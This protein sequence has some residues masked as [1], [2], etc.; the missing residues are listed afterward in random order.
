MSPITGR[1]TGRVSSADATSASRT[2]YPSIAELS[3]PGSGAAAVTSSASTQPWASANGRVSGGSGA[4]VRSTSWM[5]WSTFFIVVLPASAAL[6]RSDRGAAGR[7]LRPA[8]G[9]VPLQPVPEVGTEVFP[10]AGELDDG[11]QVVGPV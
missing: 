5:C 7:G 2:A 4:T 3:K 8:G 10:L 6:G 1:L 9:H 11:L